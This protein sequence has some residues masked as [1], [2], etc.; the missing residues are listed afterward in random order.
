MDIAVKDMFTILFIDLF[1]GS[2]FSFLL[3]TT[4]SYYFL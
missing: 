3:I 2:T 4:V 1:V